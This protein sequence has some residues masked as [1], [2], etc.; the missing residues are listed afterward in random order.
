VPGAVVKYF[1]FDSVAVRLTE[2]VGSMVTLTTAAAIV[3]TH[4]DLIADAIMRSE[5]DPEGRAYYFAVA[6]AGYG[7]ATEYLISSGEPAEIIDDIN[8][9]RD[10][11]HRKLLICNITLL[12]AN[13]R[14]RAV[15]IGVDLSARFL[16]ATDDPRAAELIEEPARIRREALAALARSDP[17]RYAKKVHEP[18][19]RALQ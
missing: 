1:D 4:W 5:H 18:L 15:A 17:K 11:A 19:G 3:A 10:F 16:P 9:A 7:R 2:E 8:A 12:I 14:R 13:I 6:V